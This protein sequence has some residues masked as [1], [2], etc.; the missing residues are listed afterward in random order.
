M[1]SACTVCGEVYWTVQGHDCPG[2]RSLYAQGAAWFADR[3]ETDQAFIDWLLTP[4]PVPAAPALR[5]VTS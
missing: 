4:A 2:P 1:T 5:L 3:G